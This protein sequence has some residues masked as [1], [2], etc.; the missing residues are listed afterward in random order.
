LPVVYHV[1]SILFIVCS[2][3]HTWEEF[4]Y[5]GILS[6][7]VKTF[8]FNLHK[9]LTTREAAP[10]DQEIA[11]EIHRSIPRGRARHPFQQR[12]VDVLNPLPDNGRGILFS[13]GVLILQ[14]NAQKTG[15]AF[16]PAVQC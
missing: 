9:Q 12:S 14:I 8:R 4:P 3:I 15:E 5:L 1:E 11:S 7:A 13:S 16:L 6:I 10:H 2:S